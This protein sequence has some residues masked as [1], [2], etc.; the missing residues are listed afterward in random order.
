MKALEVSMKMA[1]SYRRGERTFLHGLARTTAGVWV[2]T[3]PVLAIEGD[4]SI[5]LGKAV[6]DALNGSKRDIEHPTSWKGIFDPVLR[7]AKVKSWSTFAKSAKCVEIVLE[8]D[9][10]SLFPTRNLGPRDGFVR[11]PGRA[12]SSTLAVETLGAMTLLA[13]REAE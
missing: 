4:D 11:L 3:N 10:I 8:D 12:R 7:L 13:L 2:L 9:K 6:R 1:I 5:Q